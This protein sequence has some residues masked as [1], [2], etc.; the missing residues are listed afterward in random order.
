MRRGRGGNDDSVA[1]VMGVVLPCSIFFK[2]F[3]F[4]LKVHCSELF[5]L[6]G[7][8]GGVTS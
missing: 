2:I 7:E 5:F 3:L 6:L 8:A 1:G 4:L